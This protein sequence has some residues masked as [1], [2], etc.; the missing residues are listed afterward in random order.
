MEDHV[1]N[2]CRYH[3]TGIHRPAGCK[4]NEADYNQGSS[5]LEE[6]ETSGFAMRIFMP[7]PPTNHVREFTLSVSQ[8]GR[9][10]RFFVSRLGGSNNHYSITNA[11]P[12]LHQPI[13]PIP[14]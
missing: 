10:V 4:E 2:N 14:M 5:N 8:M 1:S 6:P 13:P 11:L 7:C 3:H 12:H 9:E